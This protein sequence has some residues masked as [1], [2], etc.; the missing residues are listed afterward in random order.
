MSYLTHHLRADQPYRVHM[1]V[2]EPPVRAF[3]RMIREARQ[4]LGWTQK[5]LEA[6]SGVSEESIKRYES[7]KSPNPDPD[8]VRAI[9]KAL[10]L[11]PREAPVVLGY[12]TREEMGLAPEPPRVL[13]PSIEEV[14]AILEDPK[15]S[16]EVKREWI[17]YLKFRTRDRRRAV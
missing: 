14:I 13:P 3:A 17:D 1:S 15:V 11:D 2:E 8:R 12:V 16:D 10:R 9:F 5:D 6:K 7:A 4:A